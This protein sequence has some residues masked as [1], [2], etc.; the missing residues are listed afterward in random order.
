MIQTILTLASSI[1]GNQSI[2]RVLL[3]GIEWFLEKN[4]TDKE[5][6]E[7]AVSLA[8]SLRRQGVTDVIMSYNSDRD[9][10]QASDEWDRIEKEGEK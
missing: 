9:G 8:M 3:L 6:R 1:L 7:L 2:G 10:D 4:K 5:S